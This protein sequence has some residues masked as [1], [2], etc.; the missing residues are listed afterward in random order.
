MTGIKHSS[1]RGFKTEKIHTK[2]KTIVKRFERKNKLLHVLILPSSW[3]QEYSWR[4][5]RDV[6]FKLKLTKRRTDVEYFSQK[7]RKGIQVTKN[8]VINCV[9]QH[10][11]CLF[12]PLVF[13]SRSFSSSLSH[14]ISS[15]FSFSLD[16]FDRQASLFNYRE[17]KCLSL[18]ISPPNDLFVPDLNDKEGKR[19]QC[20]KR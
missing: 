1:K 18:W 14:L 10:L 17:A 3:C 20:K 15:H 9:D 6:H 12:S 8:S 2:L 7:E 16:L 13:S 4:L 19:R 5:C 11:F